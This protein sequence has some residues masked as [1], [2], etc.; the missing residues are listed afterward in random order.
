MVR[1]NT[2]FAAASPNSAPGSHHI[3]AGMAPEC[4]VLIKSRINLDMASIASGMS[5]LTNRRAILLPTTFGAASHTR[6]NTGGT[7]RNAARRLFQE[8]SLEEDTAEDIR[9]QGTVATQWPQ[10]RRAHF[11][12]NPLK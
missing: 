1:P 3:C 2:R 7:L 5:A 11:Y 8:V 4:F 6:R 9:Y 10:T 12:L